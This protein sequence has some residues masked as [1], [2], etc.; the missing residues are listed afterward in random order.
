MKVTLIHAYSTTNSGDGLLVEEA[1]H[2][3]RSAIPEAQINLIALDP[4]SFDQDEFA[5]VLHPITGGQLTP[6]GLTVLIRGL[7][8]AV[9]GRRDKQV[10]QLRDDSN[11]LVA[12]G[13]GYLR[14]K[15]PLE[16]VKTIAAH[17][18]QL[19]TDSA[20]AV[21]LPQSIGPLRYG[22]SVPALR[23]LRGAEY[24]HLRDDRSVALLSPRV[25]NARR[26]PDMAL[27]GLPAVWQDA[28]VAPAGDRI[29]I[30]ARALPGSRKRRMEYVRRLS[31][32]LSA[33]PNH[34]LLVQAA[35]RGNNDIVFYEEHFPQESSLR[36][37]KEAVHVGAENRPNL[38]V[39]VRLHGALESI[40]S[41]VPSVHLSYE[42]KGWG[43][44][45]DMG[46]AS[47]VHNA[48][49]FDPHLVTSQAVKTASSP[50]RYWDAVRSSMPALSAARQAIVAQ[51]QRSV[52]G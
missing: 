12:V 23:R 35:A 47:F 26:A 3:V 46:I 49:A 40:R 2:I 1:A 18:P 25:P 33:I 14:A 21:Y 39:S 6:R 13:G 51:I 27:L 10:Q 29:G 31:E 4:T 52:R 41:G 37:L 11:L 38:V 20:P 34:E 7:V 36:S 50:D 9:V 19:P 8:Q 15:N 32:M 22:S 48:F 5:H 44:F 24:V 30:V 28:D 42:R 17:L 43:A 45:E 16:A